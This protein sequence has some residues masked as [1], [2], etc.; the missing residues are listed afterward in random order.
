MLKP[1]I[2]TARLD[3]RSQ[4]IFDELRRAHFPRERNHLQAC[5]LR[6]LLAD[7]RRHLT[8]YHAL[9]GAKLDACQSALKIVC[10]RWQPLFFHAARVRELGR[11]VAIDLECK[12]LFRVRRQFGDAY[13]GRFT[14]QDRGRLQLLHVTVANKLADTAE[15][16]RVKREIEAT[17]ERFRGEI[18]GLELHR[19]E[20]PEWTSIERR[21]FGAQSD[22]RRRLRR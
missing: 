10:E 21:D 17:F 5:V 22:S 4:R 11:G 20:G 16:K 19:Y 12:P 15:A 7:P 2:L 3:A 9:D 6:S 8:L 13:G 14:P 1:I 18:I